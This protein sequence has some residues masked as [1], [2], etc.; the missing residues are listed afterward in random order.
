MEKTK[1]KEVFN[2]FLDESAMKQ[3]ETNDKQSGTSAKLAKDMVFTVKG[4]TFIPNVREYESV[5]AAQTAKV[6][7]NGRNISFKD[8]KEG[9]DVVA[10]K[11]IQDNSYYALI[12]DGDVQTISLR[13][14]TSW[15]QMDD[16][17]DGCLRIP[18]GKSSTV[19]ERAKALLGKKI[20]VAEIEEWE[21]GEE[22]QGRT[23]RYAGRAVAFKEVKEG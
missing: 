3:L 11:V 23:Q 21:E 12:V 6:D 13:T 2:G 9:E 19:F 4:G 17:P 14:L 7:L 22:H 5:E 15:A 1:I 8:V 18:A 20:A 10:R 16:C